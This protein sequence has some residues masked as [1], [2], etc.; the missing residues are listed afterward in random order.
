M[1]GP[2]AQGVRNYAAHCLGL[3]SYL[4]QPGDG[5]SRPLIAARDLLWGL[6]ISTILRVSSSHQ[7][8]WLVRSP[9]RP[10]WG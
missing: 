4:E 10:A 2:S 7:L 9:A 5:R 1:K 6:L 3:K 8:E